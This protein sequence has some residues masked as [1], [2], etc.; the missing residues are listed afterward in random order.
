MDEE[1]SVLGK[2][3]EA[4][5]GKQRGRKGVGEGKFK[6]NVS[7]DLQIQGGSVNLGN[8]PVAQEGVKGY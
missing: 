3:T 1:R 8:G 6:S 2:Q 4:G 5:L 7:Q